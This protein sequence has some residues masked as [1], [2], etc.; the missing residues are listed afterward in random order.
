MTGKEFKTWRKLK[1]FSQTA[2]GEKI[3]VCRTYIW[4]HEKSEKPIPKKLLLLIQTIK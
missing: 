3:G 1:G 2:L 4:K